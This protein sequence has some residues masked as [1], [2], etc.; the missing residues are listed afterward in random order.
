V[1]KQANVEKLSY[2]ECV[3]RVIKEDGLAGKS[4]L[5]R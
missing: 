1:Y 3:S 2:A 5:L 4:L